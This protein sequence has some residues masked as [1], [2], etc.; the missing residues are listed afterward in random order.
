MRVLRRLRIDLRSQK[1][2]TTR[3]D[4]ITQ[5]APVRLERLTLAFKLCE[6]FVQSLFELFPPFQ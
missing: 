4:V 2:G 6:L 5:L 3:V 1:A